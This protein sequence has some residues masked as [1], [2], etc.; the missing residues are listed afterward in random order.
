[1]SALCYKKG[2][3][4]IKKY[5]GKYRVLCE[6]DKSTLQPIK[7][8]T[9]IKCSKEGQIYRIH[10]TTLAY[11]RPSNGNSEQLT[12]KLIKLGIKGVDNR[13]TDGDI[14]IH[15]NE[16]SLTLVASELGASTN[17]ASINPVSIRNLRQMKWF[18]EKEGEYIKKGLYEKPRELSEEEKEVY[19][20]RF[21]KYKGE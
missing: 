14:L 12:K 13:S 15:F 5:I 7:E 17:G 1:M 10:D 16:G 4:D 8:D 3:G 9:Y 18:K 6:W 20:Q 19:R 2:D 11:Y 21:E